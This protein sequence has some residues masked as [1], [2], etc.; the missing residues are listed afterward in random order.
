MKGLEFLQ[1]ILHGEIERRRIAGD[2]DPARGAQRQ[3]GDDTRLSQA[4][5][6]ARDQQLAAVSGDFR[7][8]EIP[9]AWFLG[10]REVESRGAARD[11]DIPGG[12]RGHARGCALI[13]KESAENQPATRQIDS[14]YESG[15]V[16]FA[17][18]ETRLQGVLNR[19]VVRF[20]RPRKVDEPA[21]GK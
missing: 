1:G 18:L 9:L 5:E 14:R 20:R 8:E 12:I 15:R 4:P 17:S 7:Q 3:P 11:D 13:S 16:Q 10:N 19:K 2:V 21:A 6:H